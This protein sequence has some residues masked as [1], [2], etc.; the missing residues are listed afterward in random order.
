MEQIDAQVSDL[1]YLTQQA[2]PVALPSEASS[3]AYSPPVSVSATP[4]DNS[5]L[6]SAGPGDGASGGGGIAH[7]SSKRKS[8]D[9][10]LIGSKQQRSKRNRV[11]FYYCT[12]QNRFLSLVGVRKADA[13]GLG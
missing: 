3:T 7:N 11:S 8:E 4:G 12:L 6:G 2:A 1:R 9:E 13:D 10:G 5:A